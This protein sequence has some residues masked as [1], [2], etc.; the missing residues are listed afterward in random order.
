MLLFLWGWG[1]RAWKTA[2]VAARGSQCKLG[3]RPHYGSRKEEQGKVLGHADE[4][5]AKT[6]QPERQRVG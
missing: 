4:P 2:I 5:T 6:F 1:E 3:I